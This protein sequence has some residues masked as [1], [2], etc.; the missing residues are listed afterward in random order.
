MASLSSGGLGGNGN[1]KTGG[2]GGD[3]PPGSGPFSHVAPDGHAKKLSEVLGEI[4]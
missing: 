4:V 3:V 1:G 2:E